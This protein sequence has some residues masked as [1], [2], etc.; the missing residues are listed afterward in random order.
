M[1]VTTYTIS[2]HQN[3]RV[4]QSASTLASDLFWRTRRFPREEQYALID[5]LRSTARTIPINVI[6]GW[7]HRYNG[8]AFRNHLDEAQSACAR[9]GLW[10]SF[11]LERGYLDAEEHDHLQTRKVH[12][13]RLLT[14]FGSQRIALLA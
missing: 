1:E 4:Y 8:P 10:L 13:Q 9:L 12:L 11:S 2:S 7:N 6:Q 5:Q 3:L 14:R